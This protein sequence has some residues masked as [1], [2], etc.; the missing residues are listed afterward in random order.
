MDDKKRERHFIEMYT[1]LLFGLW[2][3]NRPI[4]EMWYPLLPTK[5]VI[6]QTLQKVSFFGKPYVVYQNPM[7]QE[8]IVHSDICPH[9]GASL[10][11]GRIG[12]NGHLFCPYH[13]FE[14]QDGQFCRI[15]NPCHDP[16]PFASNIQIPRF[17]TK[18]ENDCLFV[19][20]SSTSNAAV[21]PNIFYPPEE[22]NSSFRSVEGS[23]RIP[24][25]FMAVCENLLDMLHISYVHSFGSRISPLPMKIR[26]HRLSPFSYRS[27]FTFIPHPHTLSSMVGHANHVIVENEYHL[28]TNTITRVFA[29]DLIKTVFTRSIPLSSHETLL[30][31]KIYRNFW[32]D[33]YL[34]P[35][36][37]VG[38]WI[39]QW[40]MYQTLQ[41]DIS[42]LKHVD[43]ES[44][45]GPLKVKYDVTIDH[46][47]HDYR[48]FNCQT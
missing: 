37:K 16:K 34:T 40:L 6:R 5:E 7:T 30:Y 41:E 33:D 3:M 22:F 44:R 43:P 46:F 9:Q 18:L 17:E 20:H 12:D 47:R 28:P 2:M 8:Y 42:I 48:K 15:P 32:I 1:R 35:F 11:K 14:F 29:K 27:T 24:S 26:G 45:E 23:I 19:R 4:S 13:N 39:I 21:F 10:S 31:W 36:S 38:D 25:T